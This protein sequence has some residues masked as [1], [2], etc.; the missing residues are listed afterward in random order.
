[1]MQDIL[2][3]GMPAPE[4][5]SFSKMQDAHRVLGSTMCSKYTRKYWGLS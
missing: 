2:E 5:V 4:S 1:M 3:N